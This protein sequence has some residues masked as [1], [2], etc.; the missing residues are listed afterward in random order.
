MSSLKKWSITKINHKKKG[1]V[2]RTNLGCFDAF[3]SFGKSSW[4]DA[5]EKKN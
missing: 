1:H 4:I 2:Y 3:F 5:P